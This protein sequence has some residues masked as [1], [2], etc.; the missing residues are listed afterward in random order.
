VDPDKGRGGRDIAHD[1]SNSFFDAA[2]TVLP[3]LSAEAVDAELS[4]AGGKLR[5]GYLPYFAGHI[6]IIGLAGSVRANCLDPSARVRE[7]PFVRAWEP[8]TLISVKRDESRFRPSEKYLKDQ[9]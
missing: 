5:G 6:I 8:G 1:Q 7:V 3:G 9:Q 2:V 4:P